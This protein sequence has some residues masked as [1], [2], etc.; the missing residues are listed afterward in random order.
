MNQLLQRRG[1]TVKTPIV[2]DLNTIDVDQVQLSKNQRIEYLKEEKCFN[3]GKKRHISRNCNTERNSNRTWRLRNNN[4][5]N[6]N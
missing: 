5:W 2:K 6:N 1:I 4:N 3:C